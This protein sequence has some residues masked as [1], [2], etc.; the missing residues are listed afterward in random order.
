MDTTVRPYFRN[1]ASRFHRGMIGRD[2]CHAGFDD[3]VTLIPALLHLSLPDLDDA[4]DI[5]TGT[6]NDT[7][8]FIIF[9]ELFVH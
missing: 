4:G 7:G 5:G 6:G 2:E 8:R 1:G 3:R 9:P